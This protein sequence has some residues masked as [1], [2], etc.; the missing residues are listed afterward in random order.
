MSVRPRD[1]LLALP[2]GGVVPLGLWVAG[3][4]GAVGGFMWAGAS[5]GCLLAYA[6]LEWRD[7]RGA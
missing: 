4:G 6:V 1:F 3:G 7:R 5:G 2:I